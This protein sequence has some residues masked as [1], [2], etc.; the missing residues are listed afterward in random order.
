MD[1]C[2]SVDRQ[3]LRRRL[4]RWYDRNRRDLPW[5][6]NP[7]NAYQQW[8]AEIMLQ[9]TQVATVVP[10]FR[11]FIKQFPTVRRLADAP[12]D[13]VLRLW[14]GL[15]YYARARN[16][17]KCARIVAR[18]HSGRFPDTVEGLSALPGIGRYT[19]GAIASIAFGR[20]APILDGN[21]KRVLSRMFQIESDIRQNETVDHLWTLAEA[22]LPRKRCGDFNQSLMELGAT[23]CLP[24]NP[25]CPDCPVSGICSAHA[26]GVVDEVPR[27]KRRPAPKEVQVVVAAV[28]R[29]G[30]FLIR[31]RKT[32]SLWGGM[33]ELPSIQMNGHKSRKAALAE[34][35]SALPSD[36]AFDPHAPARLCGRITRR[37]THRIMRMS[38]Y[39]LPSP[40]SSNLL[41]PCV[42]HKWISPTEFDRFAFSAAQCKIIDMVLAKTN[43]KPSRDGSRP[44]I[45][46]RRTG[47]QAASGTP[48]AD[49]RAQ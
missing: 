19:A 46:G 39:L 44:V 22:I 2:N 40:A 37:L 42:D 9:Q 28:R 18:E 16:L 12:L 33:W 27:T 21:V 47:G 17:H 10:Y 30:K 5:R 34:L 43:E 49:E 13:D 36:R 1:V 3:K 31:R 38:V 7:R 14:A 20:R 8:L 11:R 41:R 15:G 45:R 23:L 4:L 29:N 35:M 48:Y 24:R 26:A 32:D 6:R 25:K